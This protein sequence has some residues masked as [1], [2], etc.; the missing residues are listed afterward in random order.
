[1]LVT[2]DLPDQE[3]V[4]R[5]RTN[6]AE[7]QESFRAL[8]DRHSG[9]AFHYLRLLLDDEAR[10]RDCL[11]ET[12]LRVYR[13]LDR[14][15]HERS[16][17]SW[18]LGVAR[19]VG[20]DA[21]RREGVRKASPLEREP[22]DHEGPFQTALRNEQDQLLSEAVASLP[23]GERAVFVLKQVEG[24]TYREIASTIGCSERTAQ[25]RMRAAV[26]TLARRLRERGLLPGG[27]S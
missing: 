4:T 26:E 24:L 19:N 1:M 12:F 6:R 3:L 13:N 23:A 22:A 14:Y 8:Y 9:P 15:D 20:L 7:L 18:V 27:A 17:R 11:Q 25:Y 10:A 21:L 16:F 2:Q 5:C